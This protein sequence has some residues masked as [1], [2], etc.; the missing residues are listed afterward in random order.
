MPDRP[1]ILLLEDDPIVQ[2]VLSA[3]LRNHYTVIVLSDPRDLGQLLERQRVDLLLLDLGLP[4]V[5][6]ESLLPALARDHPHLPVIIVSGIGDAGTAMRLVKLGAFDYLVKPVDAPSLLKA[7]DRALTFRQAN[8]GSLREPAQDLSP[9]RRMITASPV[10]FDLFR[11]LRSV[12]PS[13]GPVL[14]TGET[15][16][17]KE[18]VAQAI[19]EC[20]GRTG[21]FVACNM[22]GLDDGLFTDTLFGH[23]RG[24]FTGAIADRP[25]LVER[26][27]GGTLFLDE[28]GDLPIASQVK[29]LRL[30]Q[31]SEYLPVGVDLP[32]RANLRIL[33]ATSLDLEERLV[34]GR[35]RRDLYYRLCGHRVHLP[36]LRERPEDLPVLIAHFAVQSSQALGRRT[37]RIPSRLLD[38][39]RSYPFPGNIRELQALVHDGVSRATGA[40]LSS[41]PFR[42]LATSG[43]AL[44]VPQLIF[45]SQLPTLAEAVQ[46]VIDEALRRSDGNQAAAARL[47]GITRQALHHR[48]RSR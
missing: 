42:R 31:E 19:H 46:Q 38:L 3:I 45:P 37:L 12:A 29:L 2:R 14:I 23:V 22:G 10:M 9:F 21:T 8:H 33:A 4:H 34:D 24:S 17:G 5:D 48:L 41:E 13:A 11:Y 27:A 40:T 20:S 35:F 16:T 32:R 39:C 25:G 1:T 36:P 6:G 47:L 30:L 43:S 26:A 7:V 44:P 28:I 18:L 15:G